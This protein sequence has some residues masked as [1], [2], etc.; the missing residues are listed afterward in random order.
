MEPIVK[1]LPL[2]V[3]MTIETTSLTQHPND[4]AII[5]SHD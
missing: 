4:P 3:W 2:S 1:S 5:T